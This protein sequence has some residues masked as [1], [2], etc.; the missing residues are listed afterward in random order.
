MEE[1]LASTP[2]TMNSV[3]PRGIPNPPH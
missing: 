2:S 1:D 3:S